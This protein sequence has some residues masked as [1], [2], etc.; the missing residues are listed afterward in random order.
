[1]P[2]RMQFTISTREG[3]YDLEARVQLIGEDILIAVWGGDRPHIGAVAAAQTQP[4]IVNPARTS[5][6]ASVL[7]FPGHR[8]DRLAKPMA[9]KIARVAEK[10]V[11]VTAGA[12]WDEINRE[13]IEK[14]LKNGETLADMIIEELDPCSDGGNG[15]E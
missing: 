7:C 9:E 14:V 12:H 5:A 3:F 4:S 2:D 8:E 10:H 13:G 11:V 6:T 15:E 1:M